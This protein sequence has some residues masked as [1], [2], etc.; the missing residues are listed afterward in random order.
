MWLLLKLGPILGTHAVLS[1]SL[2]TFL[3]NDLQL[4]TM[5]DLKIGIK[6]PTHLASPKISSISPST[7][8]VSLGFIVGMSRCEITWLCRCLNAHP[9]VSVFGQ[10]RFWGRLFQ[11]PKHQG[12]YSKKQISALLKLLKGFDW[13][14]TIGNGPGCLVAFSLESFRQMLEDVL[15]GFQHP[16]GPSEVFQEIAENIAQAEGTRYVLEKTPHH[17][18][19]VERIMQYIPDSRFIIL[20]CNPYDF[21]LFHKNQE[22]LFYHPISCSF[23]W[24]RYMV[25]SEKV[26]QKYSERTVVV[27]VNELMENAEIAL[28][29]I[30][31]FLG[32]ELYE[33]ASR[34]PPHRVLL[35]SVGKKQLDEVD[36]FWMNLIAGNVMRRND[37][38]TRCVQPSILKFGSSFFSLPSWCI[39]TFLEMKRTTPGSLIKYLITWIA[40]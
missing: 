12:N 37:Y 8:K 34:I 27:H 15:V 26:I 14:A 39:G 23:M 18:N 32:L 10:S 40:K 2:D 28:E 9:E 11:K 13:N 35:P 21:M 38:D 31:S 33:L 29:R 3:I 1:G 7:D 17:V 36:V 30:Q 5:V 4:L 16:V 20:L 19:W 25:S 24:R 22:D 6:T